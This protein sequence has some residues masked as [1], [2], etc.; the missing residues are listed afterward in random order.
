MSAYPAYNFDSAASE[1]QT[2]DRY[3]IEVI[4]GGMAHTTQ[5]KTRSL[6][7]LVGLAARVLLAFVT[8]L[9]LVGVIRVTLSSATIAVAMETNELDT[10]IED[11]REA[12]NLLEVEQ[13]TLSNPTRIKKEAAE[14]GMATPKETTIITLD[15]D[16][17][18][19]DSNGEL[20]LSESLAACAEV[21]GQA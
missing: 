18:V 2:F 16:V 6:P 20:S 21:E 9:A 17:V 19:K 12:G 13:S 8:V 10:A 3:G 1:Q 11:A 15:K 7:S 5:E 14:L 4:P